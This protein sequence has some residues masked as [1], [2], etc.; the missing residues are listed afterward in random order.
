MK[1]FPRPSSYRSW[2][3]R[4]AGSVP[5]RSVRPERM[6][7][8]IGRRTF[9][10]VLASALAWCVMPAMGQSNAPNDERRG[11]KRPRRTRDG[12]EYVL[13]PEL[14]TFSLLSLVLGRVSDRAV[15]VSAMAKEPM[16]GYFEYG[17][18]S[19]RHSMAAGST[20]SPLPV[21]SVCTRA[22]SSGRSKPWGLRSPIKTADPTARSLRVAALLLYACHTVALERLTSALSACQ[23]I[24]VSICK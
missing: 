5:D 11:G 13:P 7:Y 14:A 9:L 6:G 23:R 3:S 1:K 20:V 12:E 19:G 2:N 18:V 4:L 8:P 10:G 16:E 24:S 17:T 21:R 22:R 15:T